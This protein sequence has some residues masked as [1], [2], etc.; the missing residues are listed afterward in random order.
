MDYKEQHHE[1]HRKER[2]YRKKEQHEHE[3]EMERKGYRLH[4]AWLVGLA[5][6]LMLVAILVWTLV[7]P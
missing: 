4:P 3:R 7:L 2:E 5:I 6:S 1:H